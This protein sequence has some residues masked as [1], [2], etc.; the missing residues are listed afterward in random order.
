VHSEGHQTHTH[1]RVKTLN[2]LH[3]ANVTFLNQV[4]LIQTIAGV[5]AGNMDNKTHVRHNQTACGFEIGVIMKLFRQMLL[6]FRGEHRN[7][8]N[9][10]NVRLQVCT[11]G[12]SVNGLHTFV[13]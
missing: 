9:R 10:G 2:S 1:F 13:H 5:A 3:Q 12:Q 6:F 11:R 7:R 8:I 4:S